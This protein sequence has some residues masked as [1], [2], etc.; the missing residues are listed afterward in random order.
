MREESWDDGLESWILNLGADTRRTNLSLLGRVV[1]A[2]SRFAPANPLPPPPMPFF[3]S[4]NQHL[5][6]KPFPRSPTASVFSVL[7]TIHIYSSSTPLVYGSYPMSSFALL[8]P[9]PPIHKERERNRLRK[10]GRPLRE[11]RIELVFVLGR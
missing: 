3:P 11:G 4:N 6:P 8:P 7:N 1:A 10:K 5:T 2:R 9:L